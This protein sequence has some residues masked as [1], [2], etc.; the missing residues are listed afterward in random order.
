[1]QRLRAEQNNN[2]ADDFEGTYKKS[3][4]PHLR[5]GLL[6]QISPGEKYI[7]NPLKSSGKYMSHLLQ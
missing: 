6:F 2:C 4:M 7:I 5:Q 1:M 3:D